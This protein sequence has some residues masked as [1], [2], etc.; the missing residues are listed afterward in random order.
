VCQAISSGPP[1]TLL[2]L[3]CSSEGCGIEIAFVE[4]VAK[5]SRADKARRPVAIVVH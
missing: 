5:Q 3:C 2:D 4:A 1:T